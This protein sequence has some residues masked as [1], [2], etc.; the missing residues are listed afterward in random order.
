MKKLF[1]VF[2]ITAFASASAQQK[3]LFDIQEHLKKKSADNKKAADRQLLFPLPFKNNFTY[4]ELI[5][6]TDQFYFLSNGD[7][8]VILGIDNM[9]CIQ[10]DMRQFQAM[11]NPVGP[12]FPQKPFPG[13]I[14]NGAQSHRIGIV[15]K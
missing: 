13:Q 2:G 14:P 5:P 12:G 3:E 15:R 10:P 9:P 8:V 6:Q 7:K 1:L 4:R 11:P